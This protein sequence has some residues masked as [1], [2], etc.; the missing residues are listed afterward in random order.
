MDLIL[1]KKVRGLGELGDKVS[2]RAGYG[3]NFL[4]P[5]GFA[6]PATADNLKAFDERRA[7]LERE[8][9][10]ALA[11]AEARK[12]K[13]EGVIVTI[14]RKAG[15]EGRLFGSVGTADIAAAIT[16][17]G[18]GMELLKSEV[19]LPDGPFRAVGDYDVELHLHSDVAVTVRIEVI[20]AS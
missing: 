13:L 3:R 15:D 8:A 5:S 17:G 2:V 14:P 9:A 4:I 12:A 10:D 16:E 18:L 19:R 1:M 6:K 20:P 11:A 7:E